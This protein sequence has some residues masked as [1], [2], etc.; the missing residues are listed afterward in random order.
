VK[1]LEFRPSCGSGRR[2]GS[3]DAEVAPGVRANDLSLIRK[4]DGSYRV[5]SA[6]VR[7]SI[8]VANQLAQAAVSAGGSR[9]VKLNR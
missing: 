3:F 5:Y 7:F 9:L 6:N 4:G 8:A 1:I 2:L